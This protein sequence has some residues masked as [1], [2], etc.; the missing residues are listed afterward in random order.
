MVECLKAQG[1]VGDGGRGETG[2]DEGAQENK[3]K[4]QE[5]VNNTQSGV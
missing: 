4:L 3:M 1:R 5:T 2:R